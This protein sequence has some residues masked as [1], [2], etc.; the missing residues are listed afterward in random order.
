MLLGDFEE[1]GAYFDKEVD[2]TPLSAKET[3][4]EM[5]DD[6]DDDGYNGY[7]GYNEYGECDRG[8]YYRDGGY[9]RKTSPMMSP[10]I[11]PTDPEIRTF[12]DEHRTRNDKFHNLGRNWERFWYT[13]ADKINQENGTSFNGHQCKEKFSNL[14]R[15][16]NTI[17]DFMSGK[18]KARSRTGA[19][20]FDEFCIHFWERSEDE[21]DRVCRINT[22]NQKR[23]R[24][25]GYITPIPST[26]NVKRELRSSERWLS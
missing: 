5:P 24:G 23:S 25:S 17:C 9:E 6:L 20:Y 19:R 12:I 1:D 16:Y 8:Y 21:F 11:S 2:S 7:G 13:I 15:D 3:N 4:E 18:S 22:F 10:I 14:V 26:R